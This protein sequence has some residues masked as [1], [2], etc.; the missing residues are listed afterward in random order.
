MNVLEASGLAAYR[1]ERRV[2]E[3]ERLAVAEGET[4][5]LLGPNGAGKTSLL[6][7]LAALLPYRGEVRFRGQPIDDAGAYRRRIAVVFQ[8]PL[9]LDRSVRDN[10]AIGLELRGVPRAARA[11]RAEEELARL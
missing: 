6:L 10:A 4:L 11:R 7:A 3:A 1:G 2:V 5:A 8:R 9:L